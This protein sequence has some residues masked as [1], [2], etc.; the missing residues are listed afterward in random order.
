MM[1]RIATLGETTPISARNW[2]DQMI[3][4]RLFFHPD[5]DPADFAFAPDWKDTFGEVEVVVLRDAISRLFATLGD[6]VYEI[7][8]EALGLTGEH[9]PA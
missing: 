7:A 1:N 2:M 6:Q 5:D 8:C 3:E 9:E 4:S